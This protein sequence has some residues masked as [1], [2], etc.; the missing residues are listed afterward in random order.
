MTDT[1]RNCFDTPED[2]QNEEVTGRRKKATRTHSKNEK[3]K[4]TSGKMVEKRVKLL[5]VEDGVLFDYF[6]S[7][8]PP[9]QELIDAMER[10]LELI[11][12]F[13]M[14]DRRKA[15]SKKSSFQNLKHAALQHVQNVEDWND[16]FSAYE[17]AWKSKTTIGQKTRF[18]AVR[19]ALSNP[20]EL[21]ESSEWIRGN[22]VPSDI[23]AAWLAAQQLY[24]ALWLADYSEPV[25]SFQQDSFP[26]VKEEALSDVAHSGEIGG[27]A[28]SDFDLYTDENPHIMERMLH[29]AI[30]APLSQL[31]L[32]KAI[33]KTS[34]RKNTGKF[35]FLSFL[36]V[37]IAAI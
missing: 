21:F 1:K 7:P 8:F 26:V 24:G 33:G 35:C 5:E 6:K 30:L 9:K 10:E 16:W 12:G 18:L 20:F 13:S 4:T 34:Y 29:E 37:T 36:I 17:D 22:L 23:A 14:K 27:F 28:E 2:V 31:E 15:A 3:S 11:C 32:Q 25:F 19:L